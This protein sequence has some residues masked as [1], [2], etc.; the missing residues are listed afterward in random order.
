MQ[1]YIIIILIVILFLIITTKKSNPSAVTHNEIL[2]QLSVNDDNSSITLL[3]N[4]IPLIDMLEIKMKN[5]VVLNDKLSSMT[6]KDLIREFK[7]KSNL[8]FSLVRNNMDMEIIRA[9]A[10]QQWIYS[11]NNIS[12]EHITRFLNSLTRDNPELIKNKIDT[13]L[14]LVVS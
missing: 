7:N 9:Y 2:E 11:D 3:Q 14:S 5:R 1:E 6:I 13:A 12:L 10:L 8:Y 4:N